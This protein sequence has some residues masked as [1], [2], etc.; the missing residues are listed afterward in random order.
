MGPIFKQRKLDAEIWLGTLCDGNF[1]DV[2]DTVL[3]D[4]KAAAFIKAIAL[5]YV[6]KDQIDD[7]AAIYPDKKI[8][9]SETE[10]HAGKNSW[11]DA[12]ETYGL[13]N[14]YLGHGA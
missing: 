11:D 6:G 14:F 1:C 8:V 10:C 2:T 13:I 9:Q 7:A 3:S 4:A 5:Q 12:E